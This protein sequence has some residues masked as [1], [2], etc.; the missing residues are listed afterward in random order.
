ML[1]QCWVLDHP[2]I[3][4]AELHSLLEVLELSVGGWFGLA[5]GLVAS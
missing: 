1:T 3:L 5:L 2:G 4:L